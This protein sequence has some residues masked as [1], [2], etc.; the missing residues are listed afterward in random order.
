MSSFAPDPTDFSPAY[1]DPAHSRLWQRVQRRY[2]D[3]LSLLPPGMPD[4]AALRQC[5]AALHERGYELGAALRITRQLLM[6]RLITL[7]C[8]RTSNMHDVVRCVTTLAEVAL[9]AATQLARQELNTRHGRALDATGRE[10]QLW[11]IGMG[12]LGARELNVSSDIDLIYIYES[13]GMTEGIVPSAQPSPKPTSEVSGVCAP[14]AAQ[15]TGRISCQEYFSQ[16][17][18]RIGALIGDVSEHGFV[19]R[20]D[21]ALRPHGSSGAVAL[22]LAALQSYLHTHAREWERFAWLKSR[23]VAPRSSLDTPRVQALRPVVLPFVFRR[24]LDYGVFESL[25]QLHAQIRQHTSASVRTRTTQAV[26]VDVKLGAGG[27]RELEFAVQLLQIVR[28]GQFPELRCRPT[29]QALERLSEAALMPEQ[30]AQELARDYVLLRDVEH[31]IQYLDDQQTHSLPTRAEDLDWIA[32]SMGFS[33]ASAFMAALQA[34]RS[35]IASHFETLLRQWGV[36]PEGSSS[37]AAT[38]ALS[39]SAPTAPT[40]R[41]GHSRFFAQVALPTT[42]ATTAAAS[43]TPRPSNAPPHEQHTSAPDHSSHSPCPYWPQMAALIPQLPPCMAER[44]AHWSSDAKIC[45]LPTTTHERIA[46]LLQRTAAT[47]SDDA[48]TQL[49]AQRFI[50]WMSPLLRRGSYLAQ[51]VER[52]LIHTRLLHLLGAA[53]WPAQ[54]LRQH[55]GA[56]DELAS[57]R[58]IGSRFDAQRFEHDLRRR[59]SALQRTGEDD[60]ESLLNLLRRAHHGQVLR[61]LVRDVEGAITVEQVADDL[62]ALA[63]AI[64]SLTS[65][66][67]WQRLKNRPTHTAD[68]AHLA[69]IAY[70][71][72]GGKELGYGSDLDI[73]FVFDDPREGAHELY[74]ALARKLITWLT[75]KTSEGDLF[76]IDT[77]LRPNGNSGLLVTSFQAYANYQRQRG[78]NTAW[79]WEHQAMTRA[80]CIT[81]SAALKAA[82]DQVRHDVITSVRDVPA[83]RSE[84]IQMR[85][86]MASAHSNA[87]T[88]EMTRFDLKHSPGGMIDAEFAVQCLVLAH[89]HAHPS[90]IDNAGNIALLHRAQAAALL[91]EGVGAA[92][93][94]AYRVLRRAQHAARLNAGHTFT[95]AATL[96]EAR[97]AILKLWEVVFGSPRL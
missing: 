2:G 17:V 39:A 35:R 3:V 24:Y 94:N 42:V 68:A 70:G 85:Q 79:T 44:V 73:V 56:V 51:L 59:A 57:P 84:I 27:I 55:P 18:R 15:P 81:G 83:L 47:V 50:D 61:T 43:P 1:A 88:L 69:I 11:V 31:R 78:T 10:V 16:A 91:P 53:S 37:V 60:D 22:S 46:R 97:N 89:A 52:P 75:V 49:A 6:H 38:A 54:F 36:Q 25:R 66:W 87:Q 9:D 29:L 76:E 4:A 20:V 65:Q 80:R 30:L 71:K 21:L 72:L 48:R 63:D 93:A 45:A 5:I 62:S 41:T 33:E 23:I 86:K 82:F 32:H 14:S 74:T 19:F 34:A 58:L 95:E 64:L 7:E 67:C 8:D 12:K 92:A 77:A 90:L 96:T 28:G 26:Q 13:E 40:P